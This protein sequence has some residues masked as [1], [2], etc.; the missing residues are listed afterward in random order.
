MACHVEKDEYDFAKKIFEIPLLERYSYLDES[1]SSCFKEHPKLSEKK[2]E[3]NTVV[4]SFFE[5]KQRRR[6][7]GLRKIYKYF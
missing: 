5:E 7:R 4:D 3:I 1:R 2:C 6:N